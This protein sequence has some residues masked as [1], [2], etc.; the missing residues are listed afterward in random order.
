[1][2]GS[3]AGRARKLTYRDLRAT[4]DDGRRYEILD[5]ELYVSA[6]PVPR[7][8]IVSRNLGVMLF[9]YV[10]QRA[11]GEVFFAPVDVI[12]DR[13]TIAVP[14]IVFVAAAR[15]SVISDRA[16]EGP[17]DLL[18]EIL[19]P[20]TARRDRTLKARLYAEFGVPHYW[21]ADPRRNILHMYEASD[22]RFGAARTFIGAARASTPLFPSWRL[23]LAKVWA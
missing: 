9:D 20:S 18:V 6:S 11:L 16:V 1:M 13:H 12:L 21:I 2:A 22:R 15:R 14:D 17:P 23:D 4:P 7:H 19:S 8:Q 5:G 10:R 3:G